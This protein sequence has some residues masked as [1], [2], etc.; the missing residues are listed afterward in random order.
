M[1]SICCETIFFSFAK[2]SLGVVIQLNSNYVI[3]LQESS[4]EL[5]R[6]RKR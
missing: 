2:T 3:V 6:E 1:S 4:G 5:S